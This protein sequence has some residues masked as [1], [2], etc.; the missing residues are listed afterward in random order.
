MGLRKLI[1][2][3]AKPSARTL[4]N[5]LLNHNGLGD[6][7]LTQIAQWLTH[8]TQLECVELNGH[9]GK[10][11]SLTQI[12]A[13]L[14]Q[15]KTLTFLDVT[16]IYIAKPKSIPAA[17]MPP[18]AALALARNHLLQIVDLL[19]M[20][21]QDKQVTEKFRDLKVSEKMPIRRCASSN[22]LLTEPVPPLQFSSMRLNRSGT[23]LPPQGTPLNPL[24]AAALTRK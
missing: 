22:E 1:D 20:N 10:P 16:P 13:M 7:A 5:L 11:E 14:K 17:Q 19:E 21:A 8:N 18:K 4:K 9:H 3:L 6:Y 23:V 24:K 15:N 2:S 12:V